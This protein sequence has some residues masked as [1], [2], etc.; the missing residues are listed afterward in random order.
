SKH[1]QQYAL[2]S[3]PGPGEDNQIM[4]KEYMKDSILTKG[5]F[6]TVMVNKNANAGLPNQIV[7]GSFDLQIK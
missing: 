2:A 6:T 5:T 1:V 7:H 4:L 3:N